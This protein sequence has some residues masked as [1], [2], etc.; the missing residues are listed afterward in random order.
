MYSFRWNRNQHIPPFPSAVK[1]T[2]LAPTHMPMSTRA[3]AW[4]NTIKNLVL[5][6]LPNAATIFNPP[7]SEGGRIHN[8]RLQNNSSFLSR[9]SCRHQQKSSNRSAQNNNARRKNHPINAHLQPRHPIAITEAHIVPRPGLSA[10][11][12]HLNA[13][14]LRGKMQISVWH[15]WMPCIFQEWINS[16]C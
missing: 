12:T 4:Q 8:F 14:I 3:K 13:K 2:S 10:F 1:R 16:H 5:K 11:V 6:G 7:P 9:S 15:E